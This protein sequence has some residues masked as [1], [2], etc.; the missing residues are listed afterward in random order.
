MIAQPQIQEATIR[1]ISGPRLS[2]AG[3]ARQARAC[4][5]IVRVRSHCKLKAKYG[6]WGYGNVGNRQ[7]EDAGA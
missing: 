2:V 3:A 1:S 7:V 6:I 4:S 5:E